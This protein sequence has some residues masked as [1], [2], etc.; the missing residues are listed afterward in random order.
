MNEKP[1]TIGVVDD[2]PVMRKGLAFFFKHIGNYEVILEAGNGKELQEVLKTRS[3]PDILL[4]DLSMPVMNG[5]VTMKWLNEA[6][7]EL[8]VI[9]FTSH[10]TDLTS[11][12]LYLL[13]VRAVL[14]KGCCEKELVKAI[15]RV[16]EEGYY[17]NDPVSR[18]LLLQLHQHNGK[19][20]GDLRPLLNDKEE[21]FLQL[22]TTNMTYQQIAGVLEVSERG[23][24][25]IRNRLFEKL[26]VQNR[27]S[28]AVKAMQ[29]GIVNPA[30]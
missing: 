27:A 8:P 26:E 7:P 5:F 25:K 11:I 4:L 18:R 30:A 13:G 14:Q 2:H 12:K 9:I 29:N 1:V 23:V 3:I 22:A 21:R 15:T 20:N 17:H 19:R 10:E 6:H 16:N 28:L 24:D